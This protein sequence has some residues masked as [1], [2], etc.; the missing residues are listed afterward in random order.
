MKNILFVFPM[1][2]LDDFYFF[3]LKPP[4]I[5]SA[6]IWKILPFWQNFKKCFEGYFQF[7]STI[8]L[9]QKFILKNFFL[10]KNIVQPLLFLLYF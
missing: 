3:N 10:L 5:Q 4:V 2:S 7:S 6:K 9:C 8:F 1:L